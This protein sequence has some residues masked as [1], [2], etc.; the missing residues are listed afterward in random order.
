MA[1]KLTRIGQIW[2]AK[3]STEENPKY[4]MKLGNDRNKDPKYNI[5]VEVIVRDNEGNLLTQSKDAFLTIADPRRSQYSKGTEP[6]NLLFE[7][8]AN[9]ENK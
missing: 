5:S 9:S 4:Y 2:E 8:L 6:K 1:S 7:V 3:D